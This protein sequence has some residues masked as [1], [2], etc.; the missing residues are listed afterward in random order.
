MKHIILV[1]FIFSSIPVFSQ[2]GIGTTNPDN[3]AILELSSTS[4]GFLLPRMTSAQ[5]DAIANPAISLLIF[6]TDNNTIEF[7]LGSSGSPKWNVLAGDNRKSGSYDVGTTATGWNY[8]DVV[9]DTP[10]TSVP[11]IIL[12]FREG[13]GIDNAGSNSITHFK[14]ANASTTGFTIGIYETNLTLDVFMD[15]VATLKTQ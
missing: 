13:V 6:N 4:A 14:V 8:Y 11:A 5:R 1:W 2:V 12:T 10:F 3:S 7:N 9:F 15:W